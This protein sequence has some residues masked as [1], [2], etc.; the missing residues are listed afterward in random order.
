LALHHIKTSAERN[1][2]IADIRALK[3]EAFFLIEPNVNHFTND[4]AARMLNSY[5]H[6]SSIF[7]VIDRLDASNEDKSGLKLFF[8]RELEDILSKADD[9]ERFEKHEPISVWLH[10]LKQSGFT[11]SAAPLLRESQEVLGVDI[12]PYPNGYVGFS[13]GTETILAVIAAA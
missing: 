10:R 4:L 11:V 6:F 13:E 8:G 9:E 12:R 5:E 2:V 1:G 7:S 3:P